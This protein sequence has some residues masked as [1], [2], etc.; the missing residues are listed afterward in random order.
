MGKMSLWYA[1]FIC[2]VH[3]ANAEAADPQP[4]SP[5]EAQQWIRYTVPLPKQ[6]EITHKIVVPHDHVDIVFIPGEPLVEQAAAELREAISGSPDPLVVPDP[7]WTINLRVG[8]PDADPLQAY[9]N[10]DQACL[11]VPDPAHRTLDLIARAPHGAYYAAKT[12]QQLIRGRNPGTLATIPVMTMTDWPDMADRGLWGVDAYSHLRWLSDRK[13]NYMEQIA[14]VWCSGVGQFPAWMSDSKQLMIDEGPKYGIKP[15]PSPT[16]IQVMDSKNVFTHYPDLRARGANAHPG[17][18]CYSRPGAAEVLGGWIKSLAG[19]NN[20]TEVDVWLTENLAG[21]T[22]CQCDNAP[23]PP[24]GCRHGNRDLLE[25]RAALDGWEHAKLQYP[26]LKLRILTSEETYDS[27]EQIIAM[28]PPGVMFWYYQSLLTYNTQKMEIIPAY[29]KAAAAAGKYIG[30]CPSLGAAV[31]A[32]EPFTGAHFVRYRMNEFVDKGVSG[33]IG[34]P[35][36]RVF[37]YEFNVEAAAEWSWN[38]AGRSAHEFALS[39]AVR[40]G[41]ADPELFAQ[42]SDTLGPVAWDVYGSAWPVDEA[43][44]S[45]RTVA[46]QLVDGDLPE[47]GYVLWDVYPKPWGQIKTVQQ[48]NKDVADAAQ[49]VAIANQMGIA[50]FQQESLVIQ[51]YINSLKALYELKFLVSPGGGIAPEN[52]DAANQYF[53]M[54]VDNLAQARN[55][56]V[57][58]EQTLPPDLIYTSSPLTGETTG[59]LDTMI[60]DMTNALDQCPN[61]PYKLRPGT[62]GCGIPDHD[63]D[64]DGIPD[65]YDNCPGEANADQLDTD[66]DG[67]G[68]ACDNCPGNLNADQADADGDGVGDACDACPDTHPGGEVDASGCP[69]TVLAGDFDGDGDVDQDD[70]GHFQTCLTGSGAFVTRPDCLGADFD[71]DDDV[72]KADLAIFLSRMTGPKAPADAN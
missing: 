5:Q 43:R 7:E 40:R 24:Y 51:G 42:W 55:A 17:A 18:A 23:L 44:G 20:V 3:V 47:L 71:N 26:D 48:L 34:Y 6:I 35:K 58:W 62:N 36:Q 14:S 32:V 70:F 29:M 63:I 49:A 39:W 2:I 16:H 66:G 19:M 4:V 54:Y 50:Q 68:D 46:R 45:L 52:H 21:Y 41:L 60:E 10:S 12:L 22:G 64:G 65:Y 25:V 56:L 9:P 1:L 30:V 57:A 72:D 27:N 31:G 37:Y 15:V 8:G 38:A 13:M 69:S 11:V 28:L 59:L 61:D 33:L 53:Q 67:L